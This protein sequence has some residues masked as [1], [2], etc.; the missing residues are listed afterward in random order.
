MLLNY[1][2]DNMLQTVFMPE[3]LALDIL[4]HCPHPFYSNHYTH[5]QLVIKPS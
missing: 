1:V 5:A 3:C 4:Y 2:R